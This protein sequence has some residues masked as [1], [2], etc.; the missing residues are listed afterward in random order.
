[1]LLPRLRLMALLSA[2]SLLSCSATVHR[3]SSWATWSWMS[4][5]PSDERHEME[6]ECAAVATAVRTDLRAKAASGELVLRLV[7]PDG[8]ERH[9]QVVR[10][11]EAEVKQSW[12]PHAGTWRLFIEPAAFAGSYSIGMEASDAPIVIQVRVAGDLGR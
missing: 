2:S 6:I 9:R 3:N 7:D 10:A 12:L 1:M 8:V 5:E 11:G 4:A